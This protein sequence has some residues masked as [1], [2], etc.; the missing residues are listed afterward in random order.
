MNP[1][2]QPI[3]SVI[4]LEER[5]Q[6]AIL[7][8]LATIR[9]LIQQQSQQVYPSASYLPGQSVFGQQIERSFNK[10]MNRALMVINSRRQREGP[11]FSAMFNLHA[12][13]SSLIPQ[14]N[15]GISAKLKNDEVANSSN[16]Q[17]QHQEN[18]KSKYL[19]ET[20][21]MPLNISKTPLSRFATPFPALTEGHA[22]FWNMLPSI[23]EKAIRFDRK[24]KATEMNKAVI[25]PKMKIS[26]RDSMFPLP[27]TKRARK[28]TPGSMKSFS[29][30]W[31][32]LDGMTMKEEVFCRRIS[33]GSLEILG[34]S[35]SV[36]YLT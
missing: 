30:L 7:D 29:A 35:K 25:A 15:F 13:A 2:E 23:E 21:I 33:E 11:D 8:Q 28:L 9:L 36:K 5:K 26:S 32:K 14:T 22:S 16:P 31:K 17:S 3:F 24:R 12:S 20:P 27:S 10:D 34:N 1:S 18:N 4:G 6:K 19:V